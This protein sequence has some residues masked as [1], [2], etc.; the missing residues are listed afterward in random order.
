MFKIYNSNQKSRLCCYDPNKKPPMQRKNIGITKP[1][2]INR[3]RQ[4]EMKKIRN[5]T[6]GQ[7]TI[8]KLYNS[9]GY[10]HSCSNR[11]QIVFTGDKTKK[12]NAP[13]G[14]RGK[15]N[16]CSSYCNGYMTKYQAKLQA[17]VGAG[18]RLS[19]LKAGAIK[20]S[21]VNI[22]YSMD[23]IDSDP[24]ILYPGGI[25]DG[26]KYE[27]RDIVEWG[28]AWTEPGVIIGVNDIEKITYNTNFVGNK[29]TINMTTLNLAPNPASTNLQTLTYTLN[30]LDCNTKNRKTIL[31]R[32]VEVVKYVLTLRNNVLDTNTIEL[33]S[34]P[35]D[36]APAK[37]NAGININMSDTG[38][39]TYTQNKAANEGA[40][41][42]YT[43]NIDSS[44][45]NV[46]KIGTYNV[47]YTVTDTRN[48]NIVNIAQ[49][50]VTVV[51]TTNPVITL[52]GWPKTITLSADPGNPPADFDL[53]DANHVTI[54]D[55]SDGTAN[56]NTTLTVNNSGLDAQ[57][58]TENNFYTTDTLTA[59]N[60]TIT[61]TATDSSGN[62]STET[63]TLTLN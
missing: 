9:I 23:M 39:E 63:A 44:N 19:R 59:A 37:N 60:Y 51:D 55:N 57:D 7:N 5:K 41:T 53:L 6:Y 50:T 29:F 12:I 20:D 54:A 3:A 47:I 43:L 25:I 26:D 56:D 14:R 40:S 4:E 27:R 18:D 61:Y 52:V 35:W 17:N 38:N 32:P 2:L 36:D 58:N 8:N 28:T 11:K 13:V 30:V 46:N 10:G 22:N 34:A 42:R 31:K 21:N 15:L 1:L 16:K 33:G 49:R 45:V 24:S 48:T 62:V